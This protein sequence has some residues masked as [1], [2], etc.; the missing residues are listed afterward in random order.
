MLC[1]HTGDKKP[2][3]IPAK[4]H[5][6]IVIQRIHVEES[7]ISSDTGIRQQYKHREWN[8]EYISL[9]TAIGYRRGD[10]E[11]RATAHSPRAGVNYN[12]VR[13]TEYFTNEISPRA[14]NFI[15]P[16]D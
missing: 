16:D 3:R 11:F 13:Q 2:Y 6:A 15:E 10:I 14:R 5:K 1:S 7:K 12:R 8:V 9:T 4:C